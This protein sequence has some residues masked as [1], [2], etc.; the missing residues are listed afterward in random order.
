MYMVLVVMAVVATCWD[1]SDVLGKGA[2]IRTCG[3]AISGLST[4]TEY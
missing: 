1:L 2:M 3:S 4:A